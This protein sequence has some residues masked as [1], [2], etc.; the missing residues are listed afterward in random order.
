MFSTFYP[1]KTIIIAVTTENVKQYR[2]NINTLLRMQYGEKGP[3]YTKKQSRD[4]LNELTCIAEDIH[5]VYYSGS[6]KDYNGNLTLMALY[7]AAQVILRNEFD[8]SEYNGFIKPI[9]RLGTNDASLGTS[10]NFILTNTE[11]SYLTMGPVVLTAEEKKMFDKEEVTPSFADWSKLINP[12]AKS[13]TNEIVQVQSLL[14]EN[15]SVPN[16]NEVPDVALPSAIHRQPLYIG[17]VKVVDDPND[18]IKL[19]F[20]LGRGLAYMPV[21]Y[22]FKIWKDGI[23]FYRAIIKRGVDNYEDN[24]ILVQNKKYAVFRDKNFANVMANVIGEHVGV[25]RYL[26]KYRLAIQFSMDELAHFRKYQGACTAAGVASISSQFISPILCDELDCVQNTL[27]FVEEIQNNTNRSKAEA[28]PFILQ[29]SRYER[30][31]RRMPKEISVP[32]AV[33]NVRQFQNLV[34]DRENLSD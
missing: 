11:S 19:K 7:R 17:E 24:E 6:T 10:V 22:G 18:D 8:K 23:T 9:E 26:M 21:S 15:D 32:R 5:S 14:S 25:L 12:N 1:N 16:M 31:T 33:Y 13:A 20:G 2:D 28:S 30:N 34:I 29:K 4:E 3:R 27:Q